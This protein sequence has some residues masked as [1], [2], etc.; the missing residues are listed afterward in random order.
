MRRICVPVILFLAALV[1]SAHA[2]APKT[3]QPEKPVY[4]VGEQK[5]VAVTMSDGVVLRA[6]VFFPVDPKTGQ[7]ATGPFPVIMVQTPYGKDIVGS[8]SGAEGGAEAATQ[9]GQLPYFITRGY[10]DV[11]ADVRGTGDSGGT[12]N[13][14]DPIQGR[15][16]AQLVRWA[17]KLPHA[18]GRVGMYGPSYMGID[19]YMT[20]AA[21]EPGSP[22]KALFPI[23]AGNDTYRDIAFMGGI[24]DGEFDSAVLLS[25]FGVLEEANPVAESP[26]TDLGDLIKVEA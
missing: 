11:V 23:V 3:W 10:I 22:L 4:G 12:F 21:I 18:N 14:L 25:I 24:P 8:A 17:S 5:N 7:P 2:T 9:A 16:G 20:A 1:P 19:Q 13:L 15:D 6:N 26:P